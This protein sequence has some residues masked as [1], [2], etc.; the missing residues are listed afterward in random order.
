MRIL[1]YN[2]VFPPNG[3]YLF[4]YLLCFLSAQDIVNFSLSY[5]GSY[6]LGN[7]DLSLL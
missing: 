3:I 5:A 7:N 2:F 1:I 6:T 4:F